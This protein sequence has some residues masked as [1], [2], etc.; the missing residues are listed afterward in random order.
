MAKQVA[1]IAPQRSRP[2]HVFKPKTLV[3]NFSNSSFNLNRSKGRCRTAN[4]EA[5]A[6]EVELELEIEFDSK[7]ID[8]WPPVPLEI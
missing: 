2:G 4:D 8:H 5:R 1:N 3:S 6:P 7:L